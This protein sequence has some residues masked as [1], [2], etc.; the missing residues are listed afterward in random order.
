MQSVYTPSDEDF[1][2]IDITLT[3]P[4]TGCGYKTYEQ[5]VGV[6]FSYLNVIANDAAK[7]NIH[8][9]PTNDVINISIDNIST[10]VQVNIYNSIGQA[11]YTLKET[12]DNGFSTTLNLSDFADGIYILQIRS[13]ETVWTKKIIKR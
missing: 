10:D 6:H 11:V 2:N 5:E 4:F 1:N 8:P 12:A 3:A 7:L 9:N 13:D